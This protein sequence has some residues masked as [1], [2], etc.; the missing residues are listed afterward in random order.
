MLRGTIRD[1]VTYQ[2]RPFVRFFAG[3]R[4]LPHALPDATL[5]DAVAPGGGAL[6]RRKGIADG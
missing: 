6:F 2:R 3:A 1:H 5:P 4:A